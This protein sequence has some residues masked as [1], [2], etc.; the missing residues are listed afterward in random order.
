MVYLAADAALAVLEV[1]VH[2]DLP[3][4]LLPPDYVLVNVAFESLAGST[5]DD[6]FIKKG[7]TERLGLQQSREAGDEWLRDQSSLLLQVPSAIVPESSNLLLNPLHPLA[8]Y[9]APVST[10]AFAFDTRLFS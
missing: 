5:Q 2:L 3:P 1:R 10:R 4:D 8:V 9:L 6:G 7:P